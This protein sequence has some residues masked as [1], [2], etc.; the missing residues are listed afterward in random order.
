MIAKKREKATACEL[1]ENAN[2]INIPIE[3]EDLKLVGV[4]KYNNTT[5]VL[6]Y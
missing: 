1:P 3:F 6:F 5:K 4:L 2:I